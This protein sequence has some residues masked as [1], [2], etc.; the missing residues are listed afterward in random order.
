MSTARAS[1]GAM[2]FPGLT[3]TEAVARVLADGATRYKLRDRILEDQERD[4]VD[5]A[6]DA[7]VLL[8]LNELRLND[9]LAHAR[10]REVH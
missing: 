4:P 3:Y 5:S 9:A 1:R 7:E 2:S 8:A 10:V 6:G